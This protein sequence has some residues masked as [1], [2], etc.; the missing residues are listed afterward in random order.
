M[1]REKIEAFSKIPQPPRESFGFIDDIKKPAQYHYQQGNGCD[2]AGNISCM[3][4]GVE[5][6]IDFP[7]ESIPETAFHSLRNVLKS[8]N[9][10]EKTGSYPL[11]FFNDPTL[12]KEEYRV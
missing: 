1:N 4:N 3:E 11:Y 2:P 7:E 5:I 10:G 6:R 12:G 9:I 8:K